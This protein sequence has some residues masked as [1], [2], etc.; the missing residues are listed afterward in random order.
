[1]TTMQVRQT[2]FGW[3][4]RDVEQI[5]ARNMLIALIVRKLRPL[6]KH[7]DPDRNIK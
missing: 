7:A 4:C 3:R 6:Q 5:L 2:A 1:M